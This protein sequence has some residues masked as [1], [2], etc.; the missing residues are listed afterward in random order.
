[1]KIGDTII[2]EGT[3][4]LVTG[5]I[6]T[7]LELDGATVLTLRSIDFVAVVAA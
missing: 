4:A 7:W 5:K 1:M 2:V 3:A 6:G